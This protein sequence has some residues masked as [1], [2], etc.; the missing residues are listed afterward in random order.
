[1]EDMIKIKIIKKDT[2]T[3]RVDNDYLKKTPPSRDY[4]NKNREKIVPRYMLWFV[5]FISV[6]FLFFSLSYMFSNAI[7][8]IFPK[9]KNFIII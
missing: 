4:K 3:K 2:T 6:V 7:I 1:M 8:T 5:A 9:I